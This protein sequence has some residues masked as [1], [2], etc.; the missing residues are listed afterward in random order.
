MDKKKLAIG[1]L[2]LAAVPLVLFNIVKF[3]EGY[4][5]IAESYKK[6]P[7][8]FEEAFNEQM[9]DYGMSID[10]DSVNF[11]Y[12]SSYPYKV[13]PIQCEDGSQITCTYYP[14]SE[15]RKSLIMLI[16]FEQLL[17]GDADE[18]IYIKPLLEFLLEEFETP[19]LEDTDYTYDPVTAVT[20]NEAMQSCEDFLAGT[21]KDVKFFIT[22]GD[23][24]A[25]PVTMRKETDGGDSLSVSLLA[26]HG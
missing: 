17:T 2:L 3:V 6:T 13:V 18:A 12:G 8:Q 20:Y 11:M 26:W 22:L 7:Y 16:E 9:A 15:R 21:S 4:L 19:M 23:G 14:T 24:F 25:S 10:V 1:I 5:P